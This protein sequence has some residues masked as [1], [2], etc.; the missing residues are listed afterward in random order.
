[1]NEITQSDKEEWEGVTRSLMKAMMADAQKRVQP[2]LDR[3]NLSK[4]HLGYM[5]TLIQGPTTLKALSLNL[6]VDKANTTRAINSLR[7]I[8]YVEDDR[9]YEGS[10]KYNVFLTSKGMEIAL[11]LRAML[12]KAFDD[13]M[14]GISREDLQTL[15]SLL[16]R[17]HTNIESQKK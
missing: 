4:L 7:E 8:G 15:T 1:M 11:E 12:Y 14:I 17:I 6:C 2:Y 13:Y 10:R 9:E 16:R 3:H 5:E